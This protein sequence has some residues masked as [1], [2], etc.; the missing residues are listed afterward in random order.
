MDLQQYVYAYILAH[1]H[2][3]SLCVGAHIMCHCACVYA[4]EGLVILYKC[5]IA[6]DYVLPHLHVCTACLV[7]LST[8]RT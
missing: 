7:V 5:H 4:H 6:L 1:V 2:V 3:V 8:L